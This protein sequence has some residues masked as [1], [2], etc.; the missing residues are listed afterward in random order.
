MAGVSSNVD[1]SI[2]R[3]A[4]CW[5]D[6]DVLLKALQLSAGKNVCCIASA[7]DNALA[8]LSTNPAS[9]TAFDVSKPQLYLTAL[10]RAA[11]GSLDYEGLLCF[12]GVADSADRALLYRRVAEKLSAEEKIYWDARLDIIRQGVI[13]CGKFEGYFH[14]FRKYLLPLVH[15][16]KEVKALLAKKTNEEQLR[17]FNEKWNTLRWKMLMGVFFSKYVMG[18]YG[19]DPEFL[20]HI[21]IS[22]P[23]YIRNKAEAHLS[24][25]ACQ[26]NYLLH[27]IFT[28]RFG[29]NM[30]YYLRRENFESIR[31]NIDKLQL[32]CADAAEVVKVQPYDVYC[33]SN[34]F[35][36]M[37]ASAFEKLAAEWHQYMP[38]NAQIAFWNLMA[39]RSFSETTPDKY[40]YDTKS[41]AGNEADK[42]FFYSR[43]L[44]EHKK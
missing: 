21:N 18:K 29:D 7:G 5:E 13:H 40:I 3:Y 4:N 19:R 11:F 9:V 33:L 30:P 2:I 24:S 15:S 28:G 42:G 39:P 25:T 14:K 31:N 20:K 10:K 32:V 22:V 34:I 16:Q 26:D 36:Y 1:F 6:A 38:A 43:F 41:E 12:L 37:S 35:E 44:Y 8:L 23:A 27:M 17:H